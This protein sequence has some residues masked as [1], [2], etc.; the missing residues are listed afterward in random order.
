[1]DVN[2]SFGTVN[3]RKRN[4]HFKHHEADY[5]SSYYVTQR[6][7]TDQNDPNEILRSLKEAT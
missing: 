5:D 2:E 3:N 4:S 1:M 6:R 7:E